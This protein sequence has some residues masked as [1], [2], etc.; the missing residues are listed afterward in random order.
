MTY[1]Y[2]AMHTNPKLLKYYIIRKIKETE[3]AKD[4]LKWKSKIDEQKNT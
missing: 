3:K 1:L 2:P 4:L